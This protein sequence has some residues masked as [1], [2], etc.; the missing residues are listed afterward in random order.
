[1]FPLKEDDEKLKGG[2]YFTAPDNNTYAYKAIVNT[3]SPTSMLTVQTLAVETYMNHLSGNTSTISIINAPFPRTFDQLEINNTI[4][5]FFGALIFSIA[6]S[7]KFAS[8]VSF[9]VKERM[10]RSKHQQIVSGMNLGSYWIGNFLYDYL[11]YA[12]VAGLSIAI[13]V[14]LDV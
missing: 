5:G 7:F 8:I 14:G 1:M 10:D 12:V 4:S 3:R 6:L 9:I 13:C 2:I 11:L